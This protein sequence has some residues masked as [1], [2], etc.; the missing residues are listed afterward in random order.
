MAGS[1]VGEPNCD[2]LN[3]TLKNPKIYILNLYKADVGLNMMAHGIFL[4]GLP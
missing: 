3:L 1:T 2:S 4:Y